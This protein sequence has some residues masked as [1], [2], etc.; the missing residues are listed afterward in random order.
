MKVCLRGGEEKEEG[1]ISD[2]NRVGIV[3]KRQGLLATSH[4]SL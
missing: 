4:A 3:S 1:E 2:G